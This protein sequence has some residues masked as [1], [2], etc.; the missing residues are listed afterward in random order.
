[1]QGKYKV[2]HFDGKGEADRYFTDADVP[3]TFLLPSFYWENFIHF[4][5]GPKKG[6]DGSYLLTFPLGNE[7]MAGIAAAD[8]GACAYGIFKEGTS[9]VG[10]R[11]GVA[12]EQLTG[13]QMAAAM[14]DALGPAGA[15]QRRLGRHL[16]ELRLPRS[17]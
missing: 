7:A 1:M 12:G 14:T 3:T 16:P 11:I 9:L 8:I 10:D 15:L 4:G 6:P 5:S 13:E 2:P 17:R